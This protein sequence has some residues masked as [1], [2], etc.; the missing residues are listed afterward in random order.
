MLFM[1][2]GQDLIGIP[3]NRMWLNLML[4]NVNELQDLLLA[5]LSCHI[6]VRHLIGKFEAKPWTS[7]F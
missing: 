3:I 1:T 5:L 4:M 6:Y 7:I 2:M